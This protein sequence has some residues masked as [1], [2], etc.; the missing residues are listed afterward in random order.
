MFVLTGYLGCCVD[1][2]IVGFMFISGLS[3]WVFVS[4]LSFVILVL[5]VVCCVV[6]ICLNLLLI[7]VGC[8]VYYWLG[9]VFVVFWLVDCFEFCM[10]VNWLLLWLVWVL[11]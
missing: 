6:C 11:F 1:C 8:L 3:G 2:W 7:V 4:C 9:W 10:V 5:I